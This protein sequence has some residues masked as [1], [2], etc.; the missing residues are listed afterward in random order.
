MNKKFNAT[1]HEKLAGTNTIVCINNEPKLHALA[2]SS[3]Y[4]RL[5]SDKDQERVQSMREK[6]AFWKLYSPQ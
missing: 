1:T 4:K 5:V 3:F 2:K 6:V